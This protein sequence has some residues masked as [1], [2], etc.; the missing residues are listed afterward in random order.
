M[1]LNLWKKVIKYI[2]EDK[3]INPKD[4]IHRINES[5]IPFDIAVR[6]RMQ[7]TKLRKSHAK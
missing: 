6:M 2:S 3:V 1:Q 4:Y 5:I 7:D